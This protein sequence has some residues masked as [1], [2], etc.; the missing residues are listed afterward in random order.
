MLQKTHLLS[1]FYAI[2]GRNAGKLLATCVNLTDSI[3]KTFPAPKKRVGLNRR[4]LG[5]EIHLL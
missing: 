4:S 5:R 2:R 3:T 1:R